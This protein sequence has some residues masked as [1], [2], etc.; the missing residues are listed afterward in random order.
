MFWKSSYLMKSIPGEPSIKSNFTAERLNWSVLCKER[1]RS[2]HV[3]CFPS[4]KCATSFSNKRV[5][6]CWFSNS[7]F[8][9]W[10]LKWQGIMGNFRDSWKPVFS[11]YEWC[12]PPEGFMYNLHLEKKTTLRKNLQAINKEEQNWL[13]RERRK[14]NDEWWARMK[15]YTVGRGVVQYSA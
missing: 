4:L 3:F 5:T 7:Y 2:K 14:Q 11:F 13:Q 6:V 8:L 15:W 1:R 9:K 10:Q 12:L